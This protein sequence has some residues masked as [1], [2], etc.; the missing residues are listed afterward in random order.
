[1]PRP[2]GFS[3][4]K[5]IDCQIGYNHS[6]RYSLDEVKFTVAFNVN[7]LVRELTNY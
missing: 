3:L 5:N 7:S 4:Q 2:L 6:V 1:M